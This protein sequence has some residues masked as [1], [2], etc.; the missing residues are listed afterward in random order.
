[1]IFWFSIVAVDYKRH[2]NM[3]H[4]L[5]VIKN[6]NY[7]FVGLGYKIVQEYDQVGDHVYQNKDKFYLFGVLVDEVDAIANATYQSNVDGSSLSYDL[8]TIKNNNIMMMRAGGGS[9]GGSSGGTSS[10]SHSGRGN[11]STRPM[12]L[13]ERILNYMIFWFLF[14]FSA[15]IFYVKVLR[16]SI[17]SKRLLKMIDDKDLTWNYKGMEKQV[18]QAFYSIQESWTDM[19]MTN[20]KDYMDNDL[21]EQFQMKLEWMK[22]GDKQNILKRIRLIDLKPIS[23]HDDEEDERDLVWF[24][25]KGKMVDYTINTSTNEKIEGSNYAKSF[26]EFWKFVKKDNRWVLAK[27]LQKE[28][29]DKIPFQVKC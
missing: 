16:A 10:G 25:I 3:C 17:N 11:Y 7:E 12:S 8:D 22:M 4:P 20:S 2:V 13:L 28:E 5:F 23:I 19:D 27:I 1:M 14:F 26:V 21:Y 24:Y 15:I 6:E 29:A 18:I 9:S